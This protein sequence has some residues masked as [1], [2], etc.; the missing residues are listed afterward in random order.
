MEKYQYFIFKLHDFG[1]SAEIEC[2]RRRCVIYFTAVLI[3][4]RN[5]Q[6]C[7][8]KICLSLYQI[9]GKC[10][11]NEQIKKYIGLEIIR[12]LRRCEYESVNKK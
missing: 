10:T 4:S 7:S 3:L 5:T 8:A 9:D 6:L 2:L 12:A 11:R 1:F